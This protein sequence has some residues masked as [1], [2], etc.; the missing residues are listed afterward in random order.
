MLWPEVLLEKCENKEQQHILHLGEI[1]SWGK[2]DEM[3]ENGLLK[4]KYNEH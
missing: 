1:C 4:G 3:N 2:F